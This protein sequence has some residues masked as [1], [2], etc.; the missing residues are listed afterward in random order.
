M[1]V[2]YITSTL[3]CTCRKRCKVTKLSKL[4]QQ[5]ILYTAAQFPG[6]VGLAGLV[7][8]SGRCRR[9]LW[10]NAAIKAF[11]DYI[12]GFYFRLDTLY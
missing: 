8:H 4:I 1:G 3:N 5:F 2:A 11:L 10:S 12:S 9:S 6:N 7:L